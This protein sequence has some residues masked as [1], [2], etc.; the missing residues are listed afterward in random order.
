MYMSQT[1]IESLDI[2]NVY[3]RE[4]DEGEYNIHFTINELSYFLK[5]QERSR[6]NLVI[7]MWVCHE[8]RDYCSLCDREFKVTG[9]WCKKFNKYRDEIFHRLIEFPSIRLEWLYIHHV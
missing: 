6:D 4:M 5:V 8:E 1:F 2:T 7:P 9:E 3:Q